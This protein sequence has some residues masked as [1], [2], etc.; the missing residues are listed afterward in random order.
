M[1]GGSIYLMNTLTVSFFYYSINGFC[2]NLMTHLLKKNMMCFYKFFVTFHS[3]FRCKRT[4]PH[5][6]WRE[7]IIST[8]FPY[9]LNSE[10]NA[11]IVWNVWRPYSHWLPNAYIQIIQKEW[12]RW[13]W[14]CMHW[15]VWWSTLRCYSGR[16][17][18]HYTDRAIQIF[19]E[20]HKMYII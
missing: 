10:Y 7:F 15:A 3:S 14:W 2:F 19:Y 1:L 18:A 11:K 9:A 16:F 5:H 20:L 4:K 12:W 13:R 6:I 17:V 8:I